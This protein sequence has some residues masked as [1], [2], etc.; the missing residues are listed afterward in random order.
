MPT[1]YRGWTQP[2]GGAMSHDAQITA[3]PLAWDCYLANFD[4][5]DQWVAQMLAA[6]DGLTLT[7]AHWQVIRF[8][9]DYYN[10]HTI[11]PSTRLLVKSVGQVGQHRAAFTRRHLEA[12]FPQGGCRQAFRIAGL[13][14]HYSSGR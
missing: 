8:I 13:P 5:W 12:L 3:I 11:P 1:A 7:E 10:A 2:M 9:R 4:D 14:D 6:E